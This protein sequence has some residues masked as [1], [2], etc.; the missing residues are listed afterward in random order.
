[1]GVVV[2]SSVLAV[3]LLFVRTAPVPV[4]CG[5]SQ[6]QQ[7]NLQLDAEQQQNVATIVSGTEARH[8]PERAAVIAVATAIQESGLRNLD[9]GDR[10]SLGLFQQRPSQGW[11]SPAQVL[12][13]AYATRQF[14]NH[15]VA[16]PSWQVRPLC[17][18]AQ[19]V[20]RSSDTPGDLYA[21]WEGLAIQVVG[22]LWSGGQACTIPAHVVL[23]GGEVL[24][25]TDAGPVLSGPPH[26]DP[27]PR[28][29]CT[30]WAALNRQV[31]GDWGDAWE[32]LSNAA[33]AGYTTS[34][35]P[36]SGAIVVYNRNAGYSQYGHLGI[37]LELRSGGFVVSEANYL[38]ST[39]AV[40]AIESDPIIDQRLSRWPD[41]AVEGF[42]R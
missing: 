28:G 31:P 23:G 40:A 4:S 9:H 22:G 1:M 12:D 6:G 21:R 38:G 3:P 32:W 33:A 29:Q 24:K 7:V 18:V 14:L 27:Y 5:R 34:S 8:L 39:R 25:I 42:I 17:E 35:Q 11:G 19:A 36:A 10:D 2:L 37:V 20:Q 30:W 16:V 15:L 13:P 41:P 26:P